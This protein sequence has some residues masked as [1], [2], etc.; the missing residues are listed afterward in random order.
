MKPDRRSRSE[1][2]VLVELRRNSVFM[3]SRLIA[4]I[5]T[6]LH[7]DGLREYGIGSAQFALLVVL[8]TSGTTSRAGLG[9][10]LQQS[11]STLTRNL[12]LLLARGWVA[13][14][15]SAG[16]R[17]RAV[18][19][20]PEG[21]ILLREVGPAWQRAQSKTKRL[22]GSETVRSIRQAAARLESRQPMA[23]PE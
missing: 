1:L 19:I 7:D 20:S 2:S 11:S 9:R 5:V 3:Q 18:Q 14:T 4:R 13:E 23:L 6:R 22:L 8:M 16:R 10:D 21:L 15:G 17:G 12:Q